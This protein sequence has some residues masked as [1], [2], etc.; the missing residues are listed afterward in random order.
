MSNVSD[1]TDPFE[2]IITAFTDAT[3]DKD[4]RFYLKACVRRLQHDSELLSERLRLLLVA[5]SSEVPS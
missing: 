3:T 2:T 4:R 1:P 5:A